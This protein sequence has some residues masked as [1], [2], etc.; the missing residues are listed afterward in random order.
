[1]LRR[2]GIEGGDGKRTGSVGKKSDDATDSHEFRINLGTAQP[3]KL[4]KMENPYEQDCV[5]LLLCNS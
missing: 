3:R 4:N 1:M 5:H 2:G